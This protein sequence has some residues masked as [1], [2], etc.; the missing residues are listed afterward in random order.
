MRASD[1]DAHARATHLS[2]ACVRSRHAE[3]ALHTSCKH[4]ATATSSPGTT[5]YLH[6]YFN[7][8]AHNLL[9]DMCKAPG[10]RQQT[11]LAPLCLRMGLLNMYRHLILV[12]TRSAALAHHTHVFSVFFCG[13]LITSAHA[14][15]PARFAPSARAF[16]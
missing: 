16:L 3:G 10:Y 7:H 12:L 8:R 1:N 13:V 6:S 14:R 4:Q 15:L 9:R 2:R 11:R 5:T